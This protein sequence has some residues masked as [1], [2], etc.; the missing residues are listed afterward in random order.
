MA[1]LVLPRI[2]PRH[3][4]PTVWL[5]RVRQ[6]D[7]VRRHQSASASLSMALRSIALFSDLLRRTP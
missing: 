6:G 4:P 5:L 1:L 3:H 2:A 7:H